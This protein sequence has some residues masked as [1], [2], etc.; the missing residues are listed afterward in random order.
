MPL[1][2]RQAV[3]SFS[4]I[5]C[6]IDFHL[7]GTIRSIRLIRLIRITSRNSAAQRWFSG[8]GSV[9]SGLPRVESIQV[10][11]SLGG[12][13]QDHPHAAEVRR[14]QQQL[15]RI[16]KDRSE[17]GRLQRP[18]EPSSV[19]LAQDADVVLHIVVPPVG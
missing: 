17:I 7:L 16:G 6:A 11:I 4:F 13:L 1:A 5:C 10:G 9:P 3:P 14:Q 15:L 8:D 19:G 12:A 18:R 2:A